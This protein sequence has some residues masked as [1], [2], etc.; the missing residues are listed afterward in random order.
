MD[1]KIFVFQRLKFSTFQD[2]PQLIYRDGAE[3]L[4]H[5]KHK[6]FESFIKKNI[7]DI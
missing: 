1:Q 2:K 7:M 4:T 5:A 3:V 6:Q